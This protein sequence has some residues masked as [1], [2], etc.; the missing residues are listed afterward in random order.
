[1]L[2]RADDLRSIFLFAGLGDDQLDLLAADGEEQHFAAG[3]VLFREGEPA[4]SWWVLLEGAMKLTR[5]IGREDRVMGVMSTPGIWAGGFRAWDEAGVYVSTGH[6]DSDGRVF[7]LPAEKLRAHVESWF[8]FGVHLIEGLFQTVRKMEATARQR[9]S[10]VALGA[11]AAGLAHELNNPASA[12]SRAVDMLEQSTNT[13]LTALVHLA[14]GALAAERFVALDALRRTIGPAAANTDPLALADREE[15]VDDWLS[16]HGV[17]AHWRIAAPLAAAGVDVE[18]CARAAELLDDATLEPALAWVGSTLS[19]AALLAEV[20]DATARVSELV[21]AVKSYS[22]V[23]RAAVQPVDITEGIESTLVM[24]QHKLR[25]GVE[26]VRDFDAAVPLVEANAGELNQ[27][28]TNL[29]DNAIDAMD[30]R[31]TL[32]VST[33]LDGDRVVVEFADTGAGM[34]P[35][36][37]ARAFDPFFTTK[38]VGKGTGLGLDISRRIIV[39]RHDGEMTIASRPGA[40]VMS[41]RLPIRRSIAS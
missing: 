4:D 10:L 13:M 1:M 15:A 5:R 26:V 6:G 36:V 30:G 41:V 17:E 24:L 21:N 27:V 7:R 20:K 22:Q 19:T 11:L 37:Q 34:P 35:E 9:E 40:T 39:E 2:M 25:G 38:D 33:R 18:W 3:E 31:G 28:W 14:E 8:P 32:R 23:D 16:A 12:A 29:I